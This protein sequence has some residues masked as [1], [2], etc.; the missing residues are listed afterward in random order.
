M[1]LITFLKKNQIPYF[2]FDMDIENEEKITFGWEFPDG[3]QTWTYDQCMEYNKTSNGK[4]Y[5]NVI[6]KDSDYMVIDIDG[7]EEEYLEKYGDIL[8]TKSTG[9]ALPHLWRK[10]H[11]KDKN[12][13][14]KPNKPIQKDLLYL[15]VFESVNATFDNW[16]DEF[17][18][19]NDY[20]RKI[21]KPKSK[22]KIVKEKANDEGFSEDVKT[23]PKRVITKEDIDIIENINVE[24]LDNYGDWLKIIWGLE[25]E[26]GDFELIKKVSMK[27]EKYTNDKDLKKYIRNDKK[28]LM[29]FG[30]VA[31][32]SKLSN[33]KKYFEIKAKWGELFFDNS[34]YELAELYIKNSLDN[35]VLHGNEDYDEY[36]F[37]KD[38]FW[39]LESKEKNMIK[40]DMRDTLFLLFNEKRKELNQKPYDKQ[41]EEKLKQLGKSIASINSSSKQKSICDQ[42][43][44]ILKKK[45]Y[46][47]DCNR[48]ELFCFKNIGYNLDCN[49]FEQLNKYDFITSHCG[50]NYSK[51]EDS[52]IEKINSFIEEIQP[53]KENRECLKS[54]LRR[55]M[56]GQQ[57]EYFV[58]FNGIGGNGKGVLLELFKELL[59]T[60]YYYAGNTT[61]LTDKLKSSGANT[62]LAKCDKKRTIVYSEPE[63]GNKL[64]GATIKYV[65]GNPIVN[66]RNLYSLKT[67]TLMHG[68]TIMECNERP[69][70]TGR[71]DNS[72]MRRIIDILF[73]MNYVNSKDDIVCPEFDRLKD[74]SFKSPEFKEEHKIAL[75]HVLIESKKSVYIPKIVKER[76][77]KYILKNDDIYNFIFE[78]YETT[79]NRTDIVKIK[80]VFEYYKSCESYRF[81]SNDDKK[82]LNRS[83]FVDIVSSN[84]KLRKIYKEKV[85]ITTEDKSHEYRSVFINLKEKDGCW[86]E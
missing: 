76:S 19:F 57:D 1:K 25:N 16:D 64:N 4:K 23:K 34:D 69:P 45:D 81:L 73:P 52:K 7:R 61:V 71:V 70:T 39:S 12:K 32:Y 74:E 77:E 68:M 85:R 51:P 10:K 17:P 66:A 84:P 78:K 65:T 11:R 3:W 44:L 56:Y 36:Y 15:N 26:F 82:L 41:I 43:P 35:V 53:S 47:F 80:D 62:E 22:S 37:Y 79:E 58:F 24:Y 9:K 40:K 14:N 5:I 50:Y 83:K 59:S 60:T 72:F 48:P 86:E 75:F 2:K 49:K 13:T 27:S 67:E 18:I 28:H 8:K 20:P 63:E 21:L 38:N 31:Y 54:V 30:T 42:I 55:G 33:S 46:N 6:L 29:T